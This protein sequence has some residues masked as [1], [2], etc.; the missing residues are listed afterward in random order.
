MSEPSM[1]ILGG[2]GRRGRRPRAEAPGK[3]L[4]TRL[5]P[6]ERKRVK[7]A[8]RLNR[9]S[10]SDFVRDA[11]VTAADDCLETTPGR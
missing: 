3:P 7:K 8:A 5:S 10:L 4:T 2:H 9:Q 6:A 1:L 11:I